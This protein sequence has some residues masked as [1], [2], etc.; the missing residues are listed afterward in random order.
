MRWLGRRVS[1]FL[2]E[3]SPQTSGARMWSPK[4]KYC[5][6]SPKGVLARDCHQLIPLLCSQRTNFLISLVLPQTLEKESIK[7]WGGRGVL[8]SLWE[9]GE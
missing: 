2:Y 3:L 1:V 4:Q 5:L 7:K 8:V 9:G 6:E